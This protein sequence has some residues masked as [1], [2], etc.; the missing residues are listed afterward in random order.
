MWGTQLLPSAASANSHGG[1]GFP[2]QRPGH[3]SV[4]LSDLM[5]RARG[6]KSSQR[7]QSP[8]PR[9]WWLELIV[10]GGGRGVA[11]TLGLG[12]GHW[13]GTSA[14][15]FTNITGRRPVHPS[16]GFDLRG[17]ADGARMAGAWFLG[18][19]IPHLVQLMRGVAGRR[20]ALRRS[21]DPLASGGK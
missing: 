5:T 6:Q 3:P 8:S 11:G 10:Y 21:P 7:S 18:G 2:F 20:E 19:L 14:S 15:A 16:H 13:E 9:S 17:N 12:L 1:R 4:L